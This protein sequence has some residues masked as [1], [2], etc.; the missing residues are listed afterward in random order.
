MPRVLKHQLA[1]FLPFTV[2][3]YHLSAPHPPAWVALLVSPLVLAI[4]LDAVARPDRSPPEDLP[5]LPFTLTML[6]LAGLHA[7]NLLG[8]LRLSA[9]AGSRLDLVVGVILTGASTGY[10]AIVLAHELIH[11]R[12]PALRLLGRALLASTL[13]EHFYTEHLRGHHARVGTAEDPATAR[14]D[15]PFFAFF[16]RTVPGQLRSAW[17]LEVRRVG[18]RFW[19]NRVLQGAAAGWGALA[20]IA[21]ALG[22]SAA[23][24]WLGQAFVG[25]LLLEVVNY[26]EHWGLQ[27]QGKRVSPADSWDA[28]SWFT[29]Y[30]LVG[31]SRHADHH[32]SPARPYPA[33]RHQDAS[34][35]LPW[36][37]FATAIAALFAN[38][39]VRARLRSELERVGLGPYAQ[40]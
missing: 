7:V 27:R 18:P 34:P 17:A 30:A 37:Y 11:R 8:L 14:F 39:R 10:T 29:Y 4:A 35:K 2:L 25:V 20:L 22:P 21:G 32:A 28:E 15:E 13:Y 23:G 9:I 31:L 16:R 12:S 6:G 36:G 5:E 24:A 1:F 38:A 26:F 3:L 40:G 19:Q 33:L